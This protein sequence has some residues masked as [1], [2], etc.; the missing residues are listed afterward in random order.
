M[1]VSIKEIEAAAKVIQG[2]VVETPCLASKTLSEIAG[3]QVFLKFENHQF[4][5]SF[6]ERGALAKL[7]SLTA[8]QR[9]AGVIAVSAGNHAQGVACHA[10]R[11]KIPAVIVMP[12]FTPHVK[13]EHTR[14]FG[15]EIIL[16][17]ENFDEAKTF[18]LDLMA[19]R[20]L[21]LVH[22]YDDE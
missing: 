4:T 10:T 3:A 19:Q 2:Q 7:L 13:V 12:R 15:A 16:H 21:T 8:A 20:H 14:A 11:L 22:P 6:K 9:A 18:A 17:G 1:T 5:A